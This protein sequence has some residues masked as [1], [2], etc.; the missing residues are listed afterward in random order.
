[1]TVRGIAFSSKITSGAVNNGL[2]HR[3]EKQRSENPTPTLIDHA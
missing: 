3:I 1:M 2:S